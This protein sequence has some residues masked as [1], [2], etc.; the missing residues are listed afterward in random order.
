[1]S[2]ASSLAWLTR[3]FRK[4]RPQASAPRQPRTRSL[5]VEGLEQRINPSVIFSEN[6]DGVVAP[7][8]P[9]GWTASF[10]N[11]LPG[12]P[13]L[14]Q[15]KT[16]GFGAPPPSAPNFAFSTDFN[17]RA[18]NFLT[19]PVVTLNGVNPQISFSID[20]SLEQTGLAAVGFDGAQLLISVNG[21]AFTDIL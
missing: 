12:T 4:Q 9:A 13:P 16:S 11:T 1:M 10:D 8:L 18:N 15:T 19:S 5:L 2:L 7:N 6:F 21:G 3:T 20:F 17:D 14:W